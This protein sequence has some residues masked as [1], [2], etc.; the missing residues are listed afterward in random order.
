M[1]KQVLPASETVSWQAIDRNRKAI[2][3]RIRYFQKEEATRHQLLVKRR[4]CSAEQTN[5]CMLLCSVTMSWGGF[6]NATQ[7]YTPPPPPTPHAELPWGFKA[8][9]RSKLRTPNPCQEKIWR[10]LEDVRRQAPDTARRFQLLWRPDF[11]L[12]CI[13]GILS[14]PIARRRPSRQGVG[15]QGYGFNSS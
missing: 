7:P 5:L 8:C 1:L 4:V 6:I 13:G 3:N 15:V 9:L 11:K 2:E 14:P 10:D 12:H